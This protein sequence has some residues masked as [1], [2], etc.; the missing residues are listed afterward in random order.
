[1]FRLVIVRRNKAFV[2]LSI[3]RLIWGFWVAA[4]WRVLPKNQCYSTLIIV[5][6]VA[7]FSAVGICMD[8]DSLE[9]GRF[10]LRG[11]STNCGYSTG[12]FI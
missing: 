9:Q 5:E 11:L 7:L 8:F 2:F 10:L 6:Q 3:C 12:S 4:N 1:M